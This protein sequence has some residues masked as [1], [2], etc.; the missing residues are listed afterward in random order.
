[1]LPG[2]HISPELHDELRVRLHHGKVYCADEK[3]TRS[4]GTEEDGV[5]ISAA[6]FRNVFA[7]MGSYYF[8]PKLSIDS[9]GTVITAG[10]GAG[11]VNAA[12]PPTLQRLFWGK[13]DLGRSLEH[14]HETF[15]EMEVT[16]CCPPYLDPLDGVPLAT[17]RGGHN[18]PNSNGN[19]ND[20]RASMVDRMCY[21]SLVTPAAHYTL[22]MHTHCTL[23]SCP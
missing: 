16:T 1:M 9:T 5:R 23:H 18:N 8:P 7:A 10:C 22:P 2:D 3:I 6:A 11:H 15:P 12:S 21:R 20:S 17:F 13:K 14:F 19:E 4:D